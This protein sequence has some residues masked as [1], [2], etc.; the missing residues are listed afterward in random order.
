MKIIIALGVFFISLQT[1]AQQA[2]QYNLSVGT[3]FTVEQEAKQHITQD[4]QGT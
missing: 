2:L 4:L 3:T 1:F